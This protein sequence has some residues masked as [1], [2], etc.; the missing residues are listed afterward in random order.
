MRD[1]IHIGYILTCFW[2]STKFVSCH[3]Y[4][5]TKNY[6]NKLN[7]HHSHY[8]SHYQKLFIISWRVFSI[9]HLL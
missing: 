6:A 7:H 2:R 3:L 8:H 1:P 9:L 5:I 4:Y